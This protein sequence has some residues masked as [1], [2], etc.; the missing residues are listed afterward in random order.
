MCDS[1]WNFGNYFPYWLELFPL[2]EKEHEKWKYLT[3]KGMAHELNCKYGWMS[4]FVF[5]NVSSSSY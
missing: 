3:V 5:P 1:E 4:I 2:P